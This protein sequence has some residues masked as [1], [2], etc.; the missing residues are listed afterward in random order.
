MSFSLFSDAA[1]FPSPTMNATKSS[2]IFGRIKRQPKAWRF[3]EVEEGE[4]RKTFAAAHKSDEDRQAYISASRQTSS[5]IA[6]NKAKA[7]QATCSFPSPKPVHSLLRSESFLNVLYYLVNSSFWSLTPFSLPARPVSSLNRLL[8]IKFC[9][10][11]SPSRIGL[12]NP[13]RALGRFPLQS[14]S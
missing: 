3:G 11:L 1:L 4:R 14:T 10:F 2:I 5:V 13:G 7:W 8:C 6:K 12:T 9:S